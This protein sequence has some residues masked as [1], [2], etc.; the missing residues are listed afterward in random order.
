MPVAGIEVAEEPAANS[1]FE[2][3]TGGGRGMSESPTE[4][5]PPRRFRTLRH[6]TNSRPFS[7]IGIPG[8][9]EYP[10]TPFLSILYE[11]LDQPN[12]KGDESRF[13]LETLIIRDL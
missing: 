12:L 9:V 5:S 8:A 7:P 4:R 11:I 1:V 3:G 2:G 10:A 13:D 6:P